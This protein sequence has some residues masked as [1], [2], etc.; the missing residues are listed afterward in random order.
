MQREIAAAARNPF[1][2]ASKMATIKRKYTPL[3]AQLENTSGDVASPSVDSPD[4]P[5]TL[6]ETGDYYGVAPTG[7]KQA[8]YN[9]VVSGNLISGSALSNSTVSNC[10]KQCLKYPECKSFDFKRESGECRPKSK[11]NTISW[12][13][14][15]NYT[16][17]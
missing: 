16:R 10:A 17:T 15:D 8:R 9:H 2:M 11:S 13:N 6:P 12:G 14:Y 5:S 7:F 4:I 3:F 1:T